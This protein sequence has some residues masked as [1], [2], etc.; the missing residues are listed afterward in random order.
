M[1]YFL[2]PLSMYSLALKMSLTEDIDL[3]IVLLRLLHMYYKS[4]TSLA[5][6]DIRL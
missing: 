1:A 4:S 2:P 5:G 6:C 3:F